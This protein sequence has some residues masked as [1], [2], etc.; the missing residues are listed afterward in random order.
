M[1]EFFKEIDIRGVFI[2]IISAAIFRL[3]FTALNRSNPKLFSFIDKIP[4]SLK[5]KWYIRWALFLIVV[6]AF[7]YPVL[8]LGFND[9]AASVI[10]AGVYSFIEFT[11][12]NPK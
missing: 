8:S 3:L 7:A 1:K 5:G 4:E 6:L 11:L 12:E 9:T 10:I 2:F